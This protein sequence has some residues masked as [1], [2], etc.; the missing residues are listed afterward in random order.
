[1]YLPYLIRVL[2]TKV[3]LELLK[4]SRLVKEKLHSLENFK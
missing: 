3:R 2:D 1:M 4:S